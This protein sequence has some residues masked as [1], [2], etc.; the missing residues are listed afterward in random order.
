MQPPDTL[1]PFPRSRLPARLRAELDAHARRLRATGV[2]EFKWIPDEQEPHDLD[3][4]EIELDEDEPSQ[5]AVDVPPA[6]AAARH[7]CHAT[8]DEK[9]QAAARVEAL[10]AEF[11]GLPMADILARVASETGRSPAAVRRWHQSALGLAPAPKRDATTQERA[12]AVAQVDALLRAN[13]GMVKEHALQQVAQATGRNANTVG[14]WYLR[15]QRG[16]L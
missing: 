3:L 4:A 8:A 5:G 1:V 13:P 6:R 14:K 16:E 9:R 15:S 11:P 2:C 10:R 12:A 7:F